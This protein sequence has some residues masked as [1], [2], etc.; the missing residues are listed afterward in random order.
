MASG[1]HGS[2][3]GAFHPAAPSAVDGD[4]GAVRRV[5]GERRPD[6]VAAAVGVGGRR[7]PETRV[8]RG[9]T[10]AGRCR[11]PRSA[12]RRRRRSSRA[13]APR[14]GC[15]AGRGVA[16]VHQAEAVDRTGP[17]GAGARA[18]A[19]PRPSRSRPAGRRGCRRAARDQHLAGRLVLDAVEQLAQDPERRRDD[20]APRAR[21]ACPRRAR[22]TVTVTSTRPRERGGDPQAVVGRAPGVEADD[23]RR[24]A[25]PVGERLD[26]ARAGRGCRSPR[27]PR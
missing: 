11:R 8:A 18:S 20:A 23:E 3:G 22:S 9:A 16:V 12:G 1:S 7:Q 6:G 5:G 17:R 13:R 25:E 14:S 10:G 21:S 19:P 2:S 4:R 24:V 15:A 27:S 26:V